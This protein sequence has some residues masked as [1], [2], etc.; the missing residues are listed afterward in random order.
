MSSDDLRISDEKLIELKEN[1]LGTCQ[2]LAAGVE[3]VGL[4]TFPIEQVEDRLL[5]DPG[6]GAVEL[7]AACEWWFHSH[8]LNEAS[9]GRFVCDQ[10]LEEEDAQG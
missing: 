3:A 10:C 7:C 6:G 5:D 1:L 2:T 4:D 9:T 8:E